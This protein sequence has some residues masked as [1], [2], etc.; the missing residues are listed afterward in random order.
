MANTRTA[1]SYESAPLRPRHSLR[2]NTDGT[3][4]SAGLL[5]HAPADARNPLATLFG[6]P[7][8][9]TTLGKRGAAHAPASIRDAICR[10]FSYDPNWGIDLSAGP[11]VSDLG[12]VDVIATDVDE[13]WKRI[14]SV[15]AAAAGGGAPL[16]VFGG[17]HGCTFPVLRGVSEALPK[18]RRLGVINVDAHFDVRN[19]SV[20]S[21]GVPFRWMLERLNGRVQGHNFV[22]FGAG[23]F[24]NTAIYHDYL[25]DQQS[26]VI[27]CREVQRGNL[28]DMI[29]S[30]LGTVADGT[31]GLWLSID[32]DAI[33]AS[34]M[35]GTAAPAVGG[36]TVWQVV[37][38]VWAFGQRD[39][40]IGMDIMEVSPPFDP[41]GAS[42]NVAA[43]LALTF[44]A[45][46]QR[47]VK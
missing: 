14:S 37:E 20:C 36:L 19:S 10:Y 45:A 13:S 28:D 4:Q 43:H 40:V 3:D 11:G 33:D 12:D 23:G 41:T 35:P 39:D 6:V 38:L 9:T 16:L 46:R 34:Q 22:E 7:F 15:A 1:P 18:D 30:A 21:A 29:A 5:L 32:V 2:I 25:R 47:R 8:D 31:D 44:L 26:R 42:A 27:T 17:D 24:S